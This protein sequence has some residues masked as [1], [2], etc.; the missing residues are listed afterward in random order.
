MC[1][2]ASSFAS[3]SASWG[4]LSS[5]FAESFPWQ[6]CR[7]GF[8]FSLPRARS[9]KHS[10]ACTQQQ[11]THSTYRGINR[12]ADRRE[13]ESS[14]T[15]FWWGYFLCN[16]WTSVHL[17]SSGPLHL[18]TTVW[19]QTGMRFLFLS[20]DIPYGNQRVC[21]TET[22]PFYGSIMNERFCLCIPTV[23]LHLSYYMFVFT[24]KIQTYRCWLLNQFILT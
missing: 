11:V 15:P 20:V 12:E 3:S 10:P 22:Q 21:D 19:L 6:L 9:Y 24:I 1:S 5:A 8:I 4:A 2:W 14:S 7:T 16:I 17:S 13:K 23:W 18:S